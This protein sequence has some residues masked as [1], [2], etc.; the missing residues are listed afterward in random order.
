[1]KNEGTVKDFPSSCSRKKEC[2][3][4]LKKRT[5]LFKWSITAYY[6]Q[7]LQSRRKEEEIVCWVVTR[8]YS[9]GNFLEGF[10]LHCDN[11]LDMGENL[12]CSSCR[13]VEQAQLHNEAP[14]TT[15]RQYLMRNLRFS[16]RWL[17]RMMS[18]GMLRR[19]TLVRTVD[20]EEL[21]ASLRRLLVTASVVPSS[22]IL[23]T[24]MKEALNCFETS[25]LSRA[26]RCNIP[27]HIILQYLMHVWAMF[28][29]Q[30]FIIYQPYLVTIR[31]SGLYCT[32]LV[33]SNHGRSKCPFLQTPRTVLSFILDTVADF[34]G[35]K[36]A[37]VSTRSVTSF[38]RRGKNSGRIFHFS[39]FMILWRVWLEAVVTR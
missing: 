33:G 3:V 11:K 14:L 27:E 34:Q 15:G 16:R 31:R 35:N 36:S 8:E 37:G 26:T 18:S 12:G 29:K 5:V 38:Q 21:S 6:G 9:A 25:V 30:L 39:T 32:D 2:W 23:V 28:L 4:N 20:S 1:M 19:V 22:P 13:G 24:L 10:C 17:W 7:S